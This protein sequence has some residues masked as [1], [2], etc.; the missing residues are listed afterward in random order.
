MLTKLFSRFATN[1][2][3]ISPTPQ[4]YSDWQTAEKQCDGYMNNS[5]L[6]SIVTASRAVN[7]GKA[8]Y[9]RD[10]V[11]FQDFGENA[12]LVSALKHVAKAEGQFQVLDFGGSL[13]SIYRQHRWF[14]S[15]FK[16]FIWCVVEQ[17]Y[18]AETGKRMFENNKLK[19]ETNISD[20]FK[21]YHPNIAVLSSSLQ[22]LERPFDVLE[23][24]GQLDVPYLFVD[25][26]PVIESN[27]NRIIRSVFPAKSCKTSY[28]SW[29][30]S[31]AGFKKKLQQ[32][33][34]IIEEFEVKDKNDL[35]IHGSRNMGFF[36]EKN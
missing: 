36:C 27:E 14:L 23:D 17:K 1:S 3:I 21:Q 7:N 4:Y 12:H 20:A 15:D 33:Y 18:F 8:L 9:E 5:I 32:R 31:E 26:M 22:R 16:E 29:L 11:M 19:F 13:G 28:P 30:F 24:I 10:G 34:R 25:R 35:S 2:N 6:D